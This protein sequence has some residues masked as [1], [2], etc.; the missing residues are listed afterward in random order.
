MVLPLLLGLAGASDPVHVV[1]EDASIV[2]ASG[3]RHA[4]SAE[5]ARGE[6]FSTPASQPTHPGNSR[7]KS[8]SLGIWPGVGLTSR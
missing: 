1:V 5:L 4:G 3:A 7:I 6:T 8:S 2:Q